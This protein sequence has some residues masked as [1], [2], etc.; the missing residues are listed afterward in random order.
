MDEINF[1]SDN[2]KNKSKRK[3]GGNDAPDIKWTEAQKD[4]LR[5]GNS[6]N[7]SSAKE[8]G[9]NR[10]IGAA[11]N[12]ESLKS[13][14]QK[15]LS[16]INEGKNKKDINMANIKKE[17][18]KS[19]L[20]R[21]FN[22]TFKRANRYNFDKFNKEEKAGQADANSQGLAPEPRSVLRTP[23]A[24]N[25]LSRAKIN[26]K[27]DNAD[28]G[29]KDE[30]ANSE[31]PASKDKWK[32]PKMLKTNLIKEEIATFFNWQRNLKILFVYILYACIIIAIAYGGLFY[33]GKRASEEQKQMIEEINNIKKDINIVEDKTKEV[34]VFQKKLDLASNLLDK[35]IYWT[36]FLQFLEKNTLT[37][38][39]YTDAFTGNTQGSYS[40]QAHADSYG[41]IADQI[42]VLRSDKNV[43]EVKVSSGSLTENG[44]IG[45][46]MAL[47][48]NKDIF[49]K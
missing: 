8:G 9:I 29:D 37:N 17:N 16:A 7:S 49:F 22:A 15:V 47:T 30:F 20:L 32:A 28:T 18:G 25:D 12:K 31:K 43:E 13:P 26:R 33:W 2:S 1:L 23:N 24:R 38:I 3:R 5:T 27:D 42:M 46:G 45:F 40:F 21:L 6:G 19:S 35:H 44:D 4:R 14:R 41:A 48:I 39:Y 34:D 36:H 10:K 11:I